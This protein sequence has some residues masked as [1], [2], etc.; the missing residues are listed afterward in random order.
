MASGV[1]CRYPFLDYEVAEFAATLPDC[2]KIMGLN[3]KYIVKKMAQKYV[4]DT[5]TERKKFP[6]RAPIDITELL[7]DEYVKYMTSN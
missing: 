5:I 4:P 3:E 1:E 7:Q 2:M 6:Y